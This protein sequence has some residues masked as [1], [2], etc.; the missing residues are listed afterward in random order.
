MSIA[1]EIDDRRLRHDIVG[2][3]GRCDRDVEGGLAKVGT[4]AAV[5]AVAVGRR[6]GCH[7]DLG[8]TVTIDIASDYFRIRKAIIV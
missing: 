8:H 4:V 7:D 5:D 2:A 6:I 1:I 3:Q